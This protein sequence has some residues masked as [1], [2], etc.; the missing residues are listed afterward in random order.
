MEKLNRIR[1]L[2]EII[3]FDVL[4]AEQY[5]KIRSHL[6]KKGTPISERETQIASIALAY[7][8]RVITHNTREFQRVPGLLV[9]DWME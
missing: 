2:I 6:E 1:S 7:D 3:S 9:E 5:G 8:R 4:A